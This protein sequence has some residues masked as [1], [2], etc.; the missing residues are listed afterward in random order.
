MLSKEWWRLRKM[1]LTK[2]VRG[3]VTEAPGVGVSI[4]YLPQSSQ[5]GLG[6]R[7]NTKNNEN[8]N[9]Y[10]LPTIWFN[11]QLLL[12]DLRT[13]RVVVGVAFRSAYSA[14]NSFRADEPVQNSIIILYGNLRSLYDSNSS[15]STAPHLLYTVPFPVKFPDCVVKLSVLLKSSTRPSKISS[16]RYATPGEYPGSSWP[17]RRAV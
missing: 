14:L 3:V 1:A 5:V 15:S 16:I 11:C 7:E 9:C 2:G 13:I 12:W 10:D 4:F 6:N 8:E 17:A